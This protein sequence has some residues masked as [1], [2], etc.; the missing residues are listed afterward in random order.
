MEESIDVDIRF[1]IG[2]K[3]LVNIRKQKKTLTPKQQQ[4]L[5]KIRQLDKLCTN[6]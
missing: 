3:T 1:G 6:L 5:E 4:M 2:F